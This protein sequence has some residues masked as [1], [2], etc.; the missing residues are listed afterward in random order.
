[1]SLPVESVADWLVGQVNRESVTVAADNQCLD[2]V[3]VFIKVFHCLCDGC[4]R[5]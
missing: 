1:M 4:D 2:F 5:D 3:V